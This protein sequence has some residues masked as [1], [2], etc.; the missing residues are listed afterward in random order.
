M[1]PSR[2]SL[3]GAFAGL[4]ILP[5]RAQVPGP[6]ERLPAGDPIPGGALRSDGSLE[7][8]ADDEM[9]F[10]FTTAD[11]FTVEAWLKLEGPANAPLLGKPGNYALRLNGDRIA[12]NTTINGLGDQDILLS[13]GTMIPGEWF[14]VALV[15]EP[16]GGGGGEKR[17]YLNGVLDNSAAS[18]ALISSNEEFLIRG[19][20]NACLDGI[21]VWSVARSPSELIADGDRDLSI[22]DA[23][24]NTTDRNVNGLV[25]EWRIDGDDPAADTLTD[26]SGSGRNATGGLGADDLADGLPFRAP[27]PLASI[28]ESGLALSSALST[29]T[30]GH[31]DLQSLSQGMTLEGWV[32]LEPG[33]TGPQ[34]IIAKG[35]SWSLGLNGSARVVFTTNDGT[36]DL[37]SGATTLL[38]GRW[39]HVSATWDGATKRI[40][41][42]AL[43]D[44]ESGWAGPPVLGGFGITIGENLRGRLDEVR[45]WG[46]ARSAGQIDSLRWLQLRGTE[47]DLRGLWRFDEVAG[48]TTPDSSYVANDATLGADTTR[49]DGLALA[50]LTPPIANVPPPDG[51][52]LYFPADLATRTS[53]VIP[54]DPRLDP[55]E[56]LT[57]EAWVSVSARSDKEQGV[58][59][60][61]ASWGLLID[62]SGKLVFRTRRGAVDESLL[63]TD[64]LELGRWYHVA[65]IFDGA[66]KTLVLDGVADTSSP[67]PGPLLSDLPG[68][69]VFSGNYNPATRQLAFQGRLDTVRLWSV[70]RSL[71]DVAANI[72]HELRG[73]ED[74]LLGAWRFDGATPGFDSSRQRLHGMLAG[75]P[76]TLAPIP[77]DGLPFDLPRDDALAFEFNWEDGGQDWADI[78]DGTAFAFENAMTAEFWMRA[79]AVPAPGTTEGLVSKRGGSWEVLLEDNGKINFRTPGT[80]LAADGS[81]LPDFLSTNR[82][83]PDAWYH[84]AVVWDAGRS[85]KEIYINGDLDNSRDDLGGL[86]TTTAGGL[87]LGA[88]AAGVNSALGY[89]HGALDEVRL[90]NTALP[91]LLIRDAFDNEL[92]GDELG[93]VAYYPYSQGGR[94]PDR[95]EARTILDQP[96]PTRAAIDGSIEAPAGILNRVRGVPLGAPAPRQYALS[97]DGVEEHLLAGSPTTGAFEIN[98][99]SLTIEA[100]VNPLGDGFRNIVMQG[101]HGYGLAID[102]DNQLRFFV[103]GNSFN[104]LAS[105]ETVTNGIWQHVAVVVDGQA[106]TTTFYINGREAGVTPSAAF[107]VKPGQPLVI[108]RQGIFG[109]NYFEGLLD[110]VRVWYTARSATEINFFALQPLGTGDLPGLQ[111]YFGFNEGR[112][113]VAGSSTPGIPEATFLNM[114]ASNWSFGHFF[115]EGNLGEGLD[116]APSPGSEGLWIGTIVLNGVNEVQTAIGGES[117]D[118]TP[119]GD[120]LRVRIILHADASGAL[121]LLKDVIIMGTP[122]DPADPGSPLRLVLV[123]DPLLIPN[124]EGV[125]RRGGR[126]VGLRYG[127]VDYEFDGLELLMLGGI[128]P[129]S[130][131]AGRITLDAEHPNNPFRHKYHPQHRDGIDLTRQFTLS[132]DAEPVD[133]ATA[134]PGYGTSW[135]IGTYTETISGLHK[136]PLKTGGRFELRRLNE[137]GSLNE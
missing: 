43:L 49:V 122:S 91:G 98:S 35:A 123:T 69:V 7:L 68:N 37:L 61:G 10:R 110:E 76:A 66:T 36:V 4:L 118:L 85:R 105:T 128:A 106:G 64:P 73:S 32:Y 131:A 57:I 25:A 1:S 115:P 22:Y 111:A 80:T 135:I 81:A 24:S 71:D 13:N 95:S 72:N 84:V 19:P 104:A 130:D 93:L 40:F 121:R 136:I 74:G 77:V 88:R 125:V 53:V 109:A 14:H 75:T 132:F 87:A 46:A 12:F 18:A 65:A 41:L 30:A 6:F 28:P 70:A 124:Y 42:D 34:G 44:A 16:N 114:D 45:I 9:A 58:I 3:L 59:T 50:P 127:T 79:N 63:S 48:N 26:S 96:G 67:A 92:V 38:T 29:V 86:I 39:Y 107:V 31:S 51:G 108:G 133:P 90:W 20:L 101:D 83:E 120:T 100:W 116:L 117:P 89:F 113:I 55:I 17:I 94:L 52:A 112:G 5:C 62:P 102:Q 2:L 11:P 33:A 82:I 54:S 60:K 97:F 27:A 78:P 99:G 23:D 126:K 15:Y 56:A 103:D 129:G 21:R 8:A 119:T 47:P 137:V 134:P